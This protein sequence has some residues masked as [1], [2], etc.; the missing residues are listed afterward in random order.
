MYLFPISIAESTVYT[1]TELMI[2]HELLRQLNSSSVQILMLTVS[3]LI[4]GK[5]DLY[6]NVPNKKHCK[7]KT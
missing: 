5:F 3:V 2:L 4:I 1:Y 6:D 7:T